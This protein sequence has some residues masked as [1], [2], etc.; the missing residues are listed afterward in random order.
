MPAG[1]ANCGSHDGLG[2]SLWSRVLLS[3]SFAGVK[4]GSPACENLETRSVPVQDA[5]D[6]VHLGGVSY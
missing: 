6:L 3:L 4:M 1:N 2:L 5:D